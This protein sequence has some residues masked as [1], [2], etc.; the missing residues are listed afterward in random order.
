[1]LVSVPTI[2]MVTLVPSARSMAVGTSKSQAVPQRVV[3]LLAHVN[4]GGVVSVTVTDC[5]QVLALPQESVA[6]QARVALK[7]FPE[8]PAELVTVLTMAMVT[9]LPLQLSV[10]PAG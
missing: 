9:L 4:E 8:R 7:M 10:V 2:V 6:L 1:M 5:E 3:L